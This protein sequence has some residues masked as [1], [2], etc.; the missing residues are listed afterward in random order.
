MGK[1]GVLQSTGYRRVR[2]DLATEQQQ[3][4]PEVKGIRSRTTVKNHWC[5]L[6]QVGTSEVVSCLGLEKVHSCLIC[7]QIA[8]LETGTIATPQDGWCDEKS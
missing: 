1:L 3:T 6:Q 4:S 7:A 8:H 2:Q 5:A